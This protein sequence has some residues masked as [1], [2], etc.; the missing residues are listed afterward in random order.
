LLHFNVLN[1]HYNGIYFSNRTF[2]ILCKLPGRLE[3]NIVRILFV[4]PYPA[5]RIRARSYGFITQL[6]KHHFVQLIALC[7]NKRE[8]SDVQVL[9]KEGIAATGIYEPHIVR[10]MRGL[11]ALTSRRPLQVA[12]DGS[13]R[14]RRVIS[15]HLLHG[16]FDLLHVEL[17]RILEA[18]PTALPV[19]VV[20]DAVDCISQL[21]EQGGQAGSTQ[22]LRIIGSSEGRRLRAYERTQL[23]RFRHVLLTAERDKK[24]LLA[25]AQDSKTSVPGQTSAEITVIPLGIDQHYFQAYDGERQAETLIFSGKMSFHANIAGV[26][27]LVKDILPLIWQKRPTVRLII[28]GGDPPASIR[29]LAG[30]PRIEVT[31]Y[32]PDLRP[33]IAQAQIAVCPLPYAVGMQYKVLEA[34]ALG[35]PVVASTPAAAGLQAIAGRDLLVADEP[36]KFAAAVLGLLEDQTQ[37]RSL[38]TRGFAYI[39]TYHHCEVI[40]QQLMA[41]Y[42]KALDTWQEEEVCR[43]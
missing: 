7:A 28:A 4:T 6:A 13:S 32:L 34:M 9:Q 10:Y 1:V 37:W 12:F 31:G 21:Y 8:M 19:P 27:S 5:S 22:M 20:W 29:R 33:A 24:A 40:I 39:T 43:A 2:L 14:L 30:D 18:V 16:Q 17:I 38:A 26:C 36:A 23:Q 25:I 35:T 42:E 3:G 11:T 41:V 15:I